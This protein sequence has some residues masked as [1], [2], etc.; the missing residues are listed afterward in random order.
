MTEETRAKIKANILFFFWAAFF[1]SIG[2]N[3]IVLYVFAGIDTYINRKFTFWMGVF[4]GIAVAFIFQ[5][6]L[7]RNTA[8]K[9][10]A[11]TDQARELID[12]SGAAFKTAVKYHLSDRPEI[13][14]E[15]FQESEELTERARRI[16]DGLPEKPDEKTDKT[17]GGSK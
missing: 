9:I 6:V 16:I 17:D 13:A 12:R 7:M 10:R 8:R 4:N 1:I 15:Y 14:K 5:T 3:M 2:I 11:R